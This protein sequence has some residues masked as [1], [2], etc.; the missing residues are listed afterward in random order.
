MVNVSLIAILLSLCAT[1]YFKAARVL[2]DYKKCFQ[3]DWAE[4]Q[5]V[6]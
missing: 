3:L 2:E 1:T 5:C 6:L 4:F